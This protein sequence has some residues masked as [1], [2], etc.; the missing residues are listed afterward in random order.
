MLYIARSD[1][2]LRREFPGRQSQWNLGGQQYLKGLGV[3]FKI[4]ILEGFASV[5]P[6]CEML[7]GA[8]SGDSDNSN[9]IGLELRVLLQNGCNV[10]YGTERQDSQRLLLEGRMLALERQ[11]SLFL[12]VRRSLRRD[13]DADSSDRTVQ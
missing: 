10:R 6:C 1:P 12:I 11:V 9:N 7:I 2:D 13:R 4:E 8:A 5:G 3:Q